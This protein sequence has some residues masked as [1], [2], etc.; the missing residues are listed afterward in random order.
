MQLK[1]RAQNTLFHLKI[2]SFGYGE[3]IRCKN[4]NENRHSRALSEVHRSDEEFRTAHKFVE[5]IACEGDQRKDYKDSLIVR[6]LQESF[7]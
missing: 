1:K 7:R 2:N 3:K 6:R 5:K 4:Q